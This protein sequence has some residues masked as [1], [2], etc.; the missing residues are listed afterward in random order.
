M[1]N[2]DQTA[3]KQVIERAYIEGIHG[4][5]DEQTVRS[6]FHSDFAMLVKT[7]AGME[8]V[9]IE[10]WLPRVAQMKVDN[11]ALWSA[12]TRHQFLSIKVS[13]YA[14]V[15]VLDVHKGE[16]HFSTDYMLLYKFDEGWRIV[17]KIFTV[18]A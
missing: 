10:A 14:A 1:S 11:P 7:D 9:T 2:T 8:K 18:P 16:I 5:Q 4:T 13:G 17:S 6:G 15:A 3:I 12:P